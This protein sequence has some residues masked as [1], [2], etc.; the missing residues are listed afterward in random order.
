M[1][2]KISARVLGTEQLTNQLLFTATAEQQVLVSEP[3]NRMFE[4]ISTEWLIGSPTPSYTNALIALLA[5][6]LAS[7]APAIASN[8]AEQ[9]Q[10]EIRTNT[11]DKIRSL[12]ETIA[13]RL[14]ENAR[15]DKVTLSQFEK[16]S[17]S[18]ALEG[19]NIVCDAA[20]RP[21]PPLQGVQMVTDL[22]LQPQ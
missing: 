16:E 21:L 10:Q 1:A 9:A 18:R 14:L 17:A 7:K 20:I 2:E 19:K 5:D 3:K 12:Y 22:I 8:I 11:D 13:C 6:Q 4:K 15:A